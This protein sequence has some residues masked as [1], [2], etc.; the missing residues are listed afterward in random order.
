MD[1]FFYVTLRTWWPQRP[2]AP[3]AFSVMLLNFLPFCWVNASLLVAECAGGRI[4]PTAGA[5]NVELAYL[6]ST[7]PR[8]AAG[9]EKSKAVR[10]MDVREQLAACMAYGAGDCAGVNLSRGILGWGGGLP[11]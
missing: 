1:I 3:V 10:A 5:R 11:A 9:M 4:T 8:T 7:C 2:I 6:A